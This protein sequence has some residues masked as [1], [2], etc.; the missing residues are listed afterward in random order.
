MSHG[1]LIKVN[2]THL[3][4]LHYVTKALLGKKNKLIYQKIWIV[5]NNTQSPK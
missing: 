5:T 1:W 4:D 2:R 3:K